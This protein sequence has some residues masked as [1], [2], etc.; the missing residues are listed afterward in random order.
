MARPQPG[1]YNEQ[2][3]QQYIDVARGNKVEELINNHSG[4]FISFI[5]SV[6]DEK[7]GFTYA[8]HKWTVKEVLQHMIDAERVFVYRMLRL[9]RKNAYTMPGFDQDIFANN[10]HTSQRSLDSLKK[11][12]SL[13]RQS[14][15]IFL[16]SLTGEDL[17]QKGIVSDYPIT[18]NSLIFVLFGHTQHHI[19]ILKERYLIG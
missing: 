3:Q 8:E 5:Q 12:F 14:T 16:L 6:P 13:L 1:E 10:S 9:A 19:D 15:D 17:L 11:E 2:F 18:V 7:A 4:N